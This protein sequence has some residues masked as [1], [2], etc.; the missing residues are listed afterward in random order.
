[1][2]A[3]TRQ[4]AAS[5]PDVITGEIFLCDIEVYVLIDLGSTHSFIAS[6]IA[7]KLDVQIL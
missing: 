3:M 1:M 6:T 7:Q 5:A 4:E 2:F